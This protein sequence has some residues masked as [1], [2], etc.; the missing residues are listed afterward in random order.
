[1]LSVRLAKIKE[2]VDANDPGALVIPVSG[3][4][5]F[6]LQDMSEEERTKYC[7]EQKT[8]RLGRVRHSHA[9]WSN[10]VRRRHCCSQSLRA[11]RGLIVWLRAM[12]FWLVLNWA[13]VNSIECFPLLKHNNN[14]KNNNNWRV[15]FLDS[16]HTV[17]H[18]PARVFPVC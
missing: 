15:W 13:G 11:L 5:E 1:M 8:Q 16:G 14:W 3:A 10:V 17:R 2:W 12:S 9:C 4:L 18:S 6:K 7:E